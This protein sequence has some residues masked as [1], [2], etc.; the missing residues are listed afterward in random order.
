MVLARE[1]KLIAAALG[2][3]LVF[4]MAGTRALFE[5]L[6]ALNAVV[7]WLWIGALVFSAAVSAVACA[8]ATYRIVRLDPAAVLRRT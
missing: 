5:E 8:L 6:A 3:G 4:A 2:T 1:T 7:P